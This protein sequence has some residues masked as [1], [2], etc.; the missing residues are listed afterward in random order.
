[1]DG[2]DAVEPWSFNPMIPTDGRKRKHPHRQGTGWFVICFQLKDVCLIV[3]ATSQTR[4]IWP[5]IKPRKT[6]VW[7]KLLNHCK[8]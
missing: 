3:L 4:R 1:M 8:P 2:S 6:K 7:V 5:D